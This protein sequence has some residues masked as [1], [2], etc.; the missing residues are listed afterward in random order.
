MDQLIERFPFVADDDLNICEGHGVAYQRDMSI[1]QTYDNNYMDKFAAY[2]RG[3]EQSVNQARCN[4]VMKYLPEGS[5]ILDYGAGACGFIYALQ[6]HH[7][8]VKGF[9][10]IPQAVSILQMQSLYSEDIGLPY[11]VC[12]WDVLEHL[13]DP[14]EPL[15]KLRPGA[16]AF[17]S[18][19]VFPNLFMVR[20]S[21]HY[22]PNEHLYYWRPDGFIGYV[23]SLG[24]N[25]IETSPHEIHAGRDDVLAFAFQ[26][27]MNGKDLHFNY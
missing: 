15:R 21:K 22:R 11:G 27:K 2:D 4:F 3:I 8:K 19:P 1:A 18:I 14:S 24:F 17:I 26:K 25:F 20:S 5:D 12:F 9:D 16:M 6:A 23:K 13:K 10:V 7:F